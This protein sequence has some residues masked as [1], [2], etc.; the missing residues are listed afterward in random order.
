MIDGY[1]FKDGIA[2]TKLFIKLSPDIT[3]LQRD[4]VANG[5]RSFFKSKETNLVTK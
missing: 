4:F 2:K 1:E 3:T 5:V